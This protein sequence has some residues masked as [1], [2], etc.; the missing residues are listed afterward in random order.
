MAWHEGRSGGAARSRAHQ[1]KKQSAKGLTCH[2]CGDVDHIRR[3]CHKGRSQGAAQS[4]D[5]DSVRGV[6][7]GERGRGKGRGRGAHG[8]GGRGGNLAA[9]GGGA[10]PLWLLRLQRSAVAE[11]QVVRLVRM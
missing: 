5:G 4:A 10:L 1:E 7:R 11:P 2:K 3:N 9:A 6:R 8:R